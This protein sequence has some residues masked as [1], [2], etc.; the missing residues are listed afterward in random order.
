L[1]LIQV[2]AFWQLD[3]GGIKMDAKLRRASVTVGWMRD[4]STNGQMQRHWNIPMGMCQQKSVLHPTSSG[5][6]RE[7]NRGNTP[8]PYLRIGF[9]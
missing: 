1:A 6:G 2:N 9:E 8:E 5:T 3:F 7:V 4:R